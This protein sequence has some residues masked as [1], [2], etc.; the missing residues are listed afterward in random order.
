MNIRKEIEAL[1]G[2][3]LIFGASGF[4]GSNLLNEI[5]KVRYD[6]YA[7]SHNFKNAWRLK[8]MSIPLENIIHCDITY[9][10]SVQ[11]IFS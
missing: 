4:V 3:I 11:N 10:K 8:L 9:K 5:L 1:H 7:V 6:C 2:P